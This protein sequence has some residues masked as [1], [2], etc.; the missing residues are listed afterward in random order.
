MANE[1]EQL[2]A[3]G[4]A[5]HERRPGSALIV[6]GWVLIAMDCILAVWIWVGL[7]SGSDMWLSWVIGEGVLGLVLIFFGWHKRQGGEQIIAENSPR[8]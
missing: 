8:A 4:E 1:S 6:V 5:V 3:T 2:R 7:R